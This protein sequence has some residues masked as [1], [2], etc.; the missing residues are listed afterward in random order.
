[1]AKLS[2]QELHQIVSKYLYANESFDDFADH[3]RRVSRG[4]FGADAQVLQACL[5]IDAAL[6]MVYFDLAT[7]IECRRELAKV[8]RPLASRKP[9]R[10]VVVDA[11]QR[12]TLDLGDEI[13]VRRFVLGTDSPVKSSDLWGEQALAAS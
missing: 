13:S 10:F 1:M 2:L 12:I 8:V 9:R 7:E 11:P 6:S 4:K 3:Y 5:K